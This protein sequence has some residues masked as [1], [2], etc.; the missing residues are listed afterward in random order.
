MLP[1][2][3][4]FASLLLAALLAGAMFCVWLVFNPARLDAAHY[5][6]LQQNGIRTLHPSMPILGGLTIMATV[7]AAVLARQDKIRMSFLIVAVV[8]FVIAGL[9]TR[10]HNLPI[11]AIVMTWNSA[12]PPER[13]TELR[14]AWWRWHRIRM[15]SGVAGLAF[16]IFAALSRAQPP[17]TQG[18]ALAAMLR[19]FG[20]LI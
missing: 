3:V 8:F 2:I 17:E 16:A 9:I 15:A 18:A 5:I 6:M 14:D 10:F 11:N 13:W 4:D 7:I 20:L 12:A 1:L 19:I